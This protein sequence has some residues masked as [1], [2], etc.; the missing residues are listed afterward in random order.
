MASTAFSSLI[1]ALALGQAGISAA[2]ERD[3]AKRIHDRIAGVPPSP[4]VLD[5]MEDDVRNGRAIDAA[6]AAMESSSFYDVTLKNLVAPWTNEAMSSFV[7]LNDY[8]AT[9]IGIVRD[10]GDFRRILYDDILYVGDG[11]LGLPQ[12]SNSNNSHYEALE[13]GG[14][15][16]K[17]S[18][19]AIPQSNR[20]GLPPDATA[21]VMTSRA[22]SQA[23]FSAGTNRA[24][25]RFTLLNHLCKDLEQ[26]SDVTLPPDRIRQDVSRSPGGD[27]RVFLNNCIGCHN[28]MDPMAQAFAYYDYEYDANSDPDGNLGQLV[29]NSIGATDP[30]TGSRVKAKYHINSA[31]FEY[32]YV[33]PDDKWDNYWR[34]GANRRLG[35]DSSLT[36]SGE[37]A[38]SLGRELAHSEA[39]AECQVRK[40]F[41]NVCLRSPVDA[42]DRGQIAGMVSSFQGSGYN[43]KRVFAE[44]AQYCMGE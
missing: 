15:S 20:N 8:T 30:A 36:G 35:W 3:Q 23:F 43:L 10:D 12:Y 13:A 32:G 4:A 29:Y 27:S 22:A 16:L 24:M 34:S 19:V 38:K 2:G 31:N 1:L 39:F 17:D 33:T 14:F 41:K 18:L 28:G 21:G 42:S 6:Y 44:S 5:S 26:V 11:N 25:F 40:V 7:P 37:G 9:V